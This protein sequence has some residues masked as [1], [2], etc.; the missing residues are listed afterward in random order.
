MGAPG[1]N[2]GWVF[3]S[4]LTNELIESVAE[5]L[6]LAC[7]Q[8]ATHSHQLGMLGVV[9]TASRSWMGMATSSQCS[10]LAPW[11]FSGSCPCQARQGCF[12]AW[13]RLV[14]QEIAQP[15]WKMAGGWGWGCDLSLA[16][17]CWCF[18]LTLVNELVK[19]VQPE[20]KREPRLKIGAI[21]MLTIA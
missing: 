4:T 3:S 5:V 17:Q 15:F 6:H 20:E 14:S 1:V 8:D 18:I 7:S 16:S 19:E 2:G 21:S 12:H 10:P 11:S 9:V 13:S